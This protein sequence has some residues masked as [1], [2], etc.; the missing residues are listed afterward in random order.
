MSATGY[1]YALTRQHATVYLYWVKLSDRPNL[2][3][4][5]C[6]FIDDM[7][8]AQN[9]DIALSGDCDRSIL[10]LHYQPDG[11][12]TPTNPHFVMQLCKNRKTHY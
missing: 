2:T 3:T 1:A 4:Y 11:L 12:A 6:I 9:L 7:C 5:H 10:N 8:D